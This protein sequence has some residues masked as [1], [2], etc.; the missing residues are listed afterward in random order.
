LKSPTLLITSAVISTDKEILSLTPTKPGLIPSL[1]INDD[2]TSMITRTITA[3]T[4]LTI[5]DDDDDEQ[6]KLINEQLK[7]SSLGLARDSLELLRN[8]TPHHD[9][10]DEQLILHTNID[11]TPPCRRKSVLKSRLVSSDNLPTPA[12]ISYIAIDEVKGDKRLMEKQMRYD[13]NK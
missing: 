10:S 3:S 6:S 2:D 5:T 1:T 11:S 4:N 7:R 9:S 13:K 12:L 8:N